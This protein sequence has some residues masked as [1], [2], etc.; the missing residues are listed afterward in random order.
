M[1]ERY[2]WEIY[3]SSVN[4][5]RTF[6]PCLYNWLVYWKFGI[7]SRW[8]Q[9]QCFPIQGL[10]LNSSCV[11]VSWSQNKKQQQK[12]SKY[13]WERPRDAFVQCCTDQCTD[14]QW[15]G[16]TSDW[17]ILVRL[18]NKEFKNDRSVLF[19]CVKLSIWKYWNNG[20]TIISGC[21]T[22]THTATKFLKSICESNQALKN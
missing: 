11:W 20:V 7:L 3:D 5:I 16:V 9:E 21:V 13:G 19:M 1:P 22:I 15:V 17:H 2:H 18:R 12:I 14:M 10:D 6:L 8:H 4:V